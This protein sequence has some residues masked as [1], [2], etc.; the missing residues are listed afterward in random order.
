VRLKYY[1]DPKKWTANRNL[2]DEERMRR[3]FV[4]P[5]QM[6]KSDEIIRRLLV[7]AL[8]S[9]KPAALLSTVFASMNQE[10]K[11]DHSNA[12][13]FFRARYHSAWCHNLAWVNLCVGKPKILTI[14][15]LPFMH[16]CHHCQ[17]TFGFQL[18]VNGV[19]LPGSVLE[20]IP[21]TPKQIE[22]DR[23]LY[24]CIN[25]LRNDGLFDPVL[26]EITKALRRLKDGILAYHIVP[27]ITHYATL[28]PGQHSATPLAISSGRWL[29]P[30]DEGA[31]SNESFLSDFQKKYYVPCLFCR[32]AGGII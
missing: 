5:Q 2:A 32:G 16:Q 20:P 4:V 6:I 21:L 27:I 30:A 8:E 7:K 1:I 10:E 22:I 28:K 29:T 18:P 26:K 14:R 3:S 23:M 19:H 13:L 25:N 11:A 15:N 31:V 24:S 12:Q 9:K 17:S